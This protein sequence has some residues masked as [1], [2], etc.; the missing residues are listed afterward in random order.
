[1]RGGHEQGTAIAIE[2]ASGGGVGDG[3]GGWGQRLN[4][5]PQNGCVGWGLGLHVRCRL[6]S[7]GRASELFQASACALEDADALLSLWQVE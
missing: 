4:M 7:F 6:S 2:R 3:V 5:A 1:M